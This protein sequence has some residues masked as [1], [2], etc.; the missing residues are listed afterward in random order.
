MYTIYYL[1]KRRSLSTRYLCT[2]VYNTCIQLGPYKLRYCIICFVRPLHSK[3]GMES[4]HCYY[5]S[6]TDQLSWWTYGAIINR[7]D[8]AVDY[9]SSLLGI[10]IMVGCVLSQLKPSELY[11]LSCGKGLGLRP[12]PFPQLRM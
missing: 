2:G 9:G 1:Q 8:R 5:W 3:P 7:C 6:S 4:Y 10:L 12:G 11:I